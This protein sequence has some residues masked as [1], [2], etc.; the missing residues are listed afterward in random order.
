MSVAIAEF[1]TSDYTSVEVTAGISQLSDI[2]NPL[3]DVNPAHVTSLKESFKRDGYRY[4]YGMIS[5]TPS[6]ADIASAEMSD[7]ATM[8]D[9]RL[10][11]NSSIRLFVVDGRHRLAAIDALGK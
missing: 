2:L 8:R 5:I 1:N 4:R 6:T 3:R 11:L 9:G 7:I 10:V